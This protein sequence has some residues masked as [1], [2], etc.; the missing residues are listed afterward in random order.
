MHFTRFA[1]TAMIVLICALPA[2][3]Q[4][5]AVTK[6]GDPITEAEIEQRTKLNFLVRHKHPERQDV[7]SELVDDK[8]SIK[9]VHPTTTQV[10]D[11]FAEMCTRMRVTPE[12][13]TA[14]LEDRGVGVDTLKLRIKADMA[15]SRLARIRYYKYNDHLSPR[16]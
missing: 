3:A 11:A 4:T 15:R 1:L 14:S 6:Y 12:R 9:E 10:D 2:H 5:A 8:N 13:L 16:W 7:I